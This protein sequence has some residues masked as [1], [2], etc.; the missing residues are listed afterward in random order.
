MTPPV[1]LEVTDGVALLGLAR[2]ERNNAVDL[3]LARA[4]RDAVAEVA[5]TPD[6]GAAVLFGHGEQ[7][8]VGGDLL[9]FADAEAPGQFLAELARTAHEA[10]LGLRSL[11]VPVVASVQGACAGAGIGFALSADLVLAEHTARFVVAYTATGLSPDCGVSWALTRALGP[12]RASDLILT[13]RKVEGT[14]AERIGL[15]SRA[16]APGTARAE[17]VRLATALARG[18]RRAL[19]ASAGLVRRAV[20]EPLSGHLDAEARSIAALIETPDGQEGV[21]AFLAKRTPR[22]THTTAGAADHD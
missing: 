4:L 6:V 20:S 21:H 8:S 3:P 2:P 13:N 5:A 1:T 10:V 19:A 12:A 14:E 16:V 7:F 9:A 22:F 11:T 15:V 18:P 17:A